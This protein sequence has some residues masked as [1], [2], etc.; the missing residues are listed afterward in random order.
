M[1]R[2]AVA[3][4]LL[5]SALVGGCSSTA[6]DDE[7]AEAV[8]GSLTAAAGT[9]SAD[10]ASA[11]AGDWTRLVF[12]CAY[13]DRA[14]VEESLGFA[15]PEYRPTDQDSENIWI[16]ATDREVVTWAMIPGYHGDPCYYEGARPPEV[17]P[18]LEAE[19]RVEDTGERVL[20]DLPYRALRPLN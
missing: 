18:R 13:A 14:S 3:A 17:V 12:A 5:A 4:W 9:G 15:W 16:F 1:D 8:I 7:T 19:F 6:G 2:R 10:L 20:D 11:V